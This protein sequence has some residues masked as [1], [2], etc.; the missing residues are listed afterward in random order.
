MPLLKASR[1]PG[2]SPWPR[3]A[4]PAQGPRLHREPRETHLADPAW[5]PGIMQCRAAAARSVGPPQS[6]GSPKARDV[7]HLPA[8]AR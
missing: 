5:S 8:D 7:T 2:P 3:S 1:P 6:S 4:G